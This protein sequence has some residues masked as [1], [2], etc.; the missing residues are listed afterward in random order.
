MAVMDPKRRSIFEVIG[1]GVL[2]GAVVFFY[3]MG[4]RNGERNAEAKVLEVRN[5]LKAQLAAKDQDLRQCTNTTAQLQ[6]VLQLKDADRNRLLEITTVEP[7]LRLTY[8]GRPL[9][10]RVVMAQEHVVTRCFQPIVW[11]ENTGVRDVRVEGGEAVTPAPFVSSSQAQPLSEDKGTKYRH[12]IEIQ[13]VVITPG[14][15]RWAQWEICRADK[16]IQPGETVSVQLAVFADGFLPLRETVDFVA[17]PV[18]A[19]SHP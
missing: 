18:S 2:F 11:M 7:P 13:A 1:A 8:L 9:K 3:N 6:A 4:D 16:N 10:G 14:G 12:W 15:R 5:D 19:A 17:P